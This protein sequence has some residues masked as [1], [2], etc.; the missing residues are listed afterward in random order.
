MP[1]RKKSLLGAS[2]P[3][4]ADPAFLPTLSSNL[5]ALGP[6]T[7]SAPL[8]PPPILTSPMPLSSPAAMTPAPTPTPS[9]PVA[10]S[11]SLVNK[12]GTQSLYQRC[13]FA[14]ARLLRI[15][16]IPAF[17]TLANSGRAPPRKGLAPVE[18]DADTKEKDRPRARQST[19]PVRQVWDLLALG[20]PLCILYNAQP[21]VEP[22][23]IDV[24]CEEA[25]KNLAS[26]KHAKR[27]TA[28]FVMGANGLIKSGEWTCQSEMFTVSE[29]LGNNTNG[30]VKVVNNVLYLLDRLPESI[31][32]PAPPSPPSLVSHFSSS[33]YPATPGLIASDSVDSLTSPATETPPNGFPFPP[34]GGADEDESARKTHI[35]HIMDAERKYVTDLEVMHEYARELV[36]KDVVTADT[37][38]HLFPG[39][40]K[41]LDFGRRF[42]IEMEGVAECPWEEQRWGA[43]F[44]KNEDEFAVYEPYCANYTNASELMV[45]QEQ[46]LMGLAHVINPKGELPMFLIKPIQKICKYHLQ[47]HD[48]IKRAN[49]STYPYYAELEQGIAVAK[50]IA[51]QAN[52]TQRKVENRNTVKAL[53]A[54]VEDWKGHHLPNFGDLLLDEVF[55]VTKADVDREYH[56]FLFEKIILCCKEVLPVDAKKGGKGVGKTNSMLR[57]QQSG[58]GGVPGT[59]LMP[60]TPGGKKK[61]PLLL[62]GRIFLNNVTRT[63]VVPGGYSLQVWWRGD[64]DLEYFTLR[65]RSEEQLTRWETS[66]NQLIADNAARRASERAARQQHHHDRTLSTNSAVSYATSL[67]AYPPPPAYPGRPQGYED[68]TGYPASG[69]ATPLEARRSQPP[70][71][72]REREYERPR[73]RTE[74]ADGAVM[75]QYR[76]HAAPMPPSMPRGAMAPVRGASEAS[77][78]P[79]R[80]SSVQP[81]VSGPGP[82]LKSKFSSTRLRANYEQGPNDGM[83]RVYE[84]GYG[85]DGVRLD[86]DGYE[87]ARDSATTPTPRTNGA[88]PPHLRMRSASQPS[89][90]VQVQ[91]QQQPPPPVPRWNGAVN[92]SASSLSTSPEEKRGSGSSESTRA[93][94]EYSPTNTQSPITPFGDGGA[95]RVLGLGAG[96]SVRVKV[97]YKADLFQIIVPRDTVFNE[98]VSKVA[99]KVRLC[100]GNGRDDKDLPLRVKYRDEDGDMISLGS[101]DDVQMAFDGTRTSSGGVELWVS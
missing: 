20:V 55:I 50:R 66:I 53:E 32:S 97:H 93:S 95:R 36:Q 9:A 40:S 49:K 1:P 51:D 2:N 76:Q 29:L 15:D 81:R 73:A 74:G 100:G 31:F 65:C 24:S 45:A 101:D 86:A 61:T 21:G 96:E 90:Y 91:Q 63:S 78:G 23:P 89:A 10:N 5:A 68:E 57:K 16:G 60:P 62:K 98:L 44:V 12:T 47:L 88:A 30:F 18:D 67:P 70:E 72:E 94:S 28:L 77:F 84:S 26:N 52:E 7:H 14:L 71:R 87:L 19:D 69:R 41:L 58:A 25:E 82:G 59:P 4:L 11:M 17:F 35:K 46:N 92:G 22:L 8:P 83:P 56:V 42:L 27:A 48:L 64:E 6:N 34:T 75:M 43:L 33:G 85:E 38:H 37:V 80:E 39:L 54:R 13:S 3:L 99:Y 79:G